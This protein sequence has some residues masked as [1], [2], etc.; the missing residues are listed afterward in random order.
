MV[1]LMEFGVMS[2]VLMIMR[3]VLPGVLMF[4]HPGIARM[5]M[6]M[7]MFMGV[8]VGV[9]MQMDFIPM[10]VLMAVHVGMLMGVQMLMFVLAFHGCLLFLEKNL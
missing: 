3:T 6:L 10:P 9:L 7:G 8:G 4:V 2:G 5:G 1:M